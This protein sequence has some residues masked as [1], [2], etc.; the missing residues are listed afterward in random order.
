MPRNNTRKQRGGNKSNEPFEITP[1]KYMG[2]MAPYIFMIQQR[3][4]GRYYCDFISVNGGT[5]KFL[6]VFTSL[7]EPGDPK[8]RLRK[9]IRE[10]RAIDAAP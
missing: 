9:A 6:R 8:Q 4:D 5:Y 10:R 7:S 1:Q 2:V 3:D